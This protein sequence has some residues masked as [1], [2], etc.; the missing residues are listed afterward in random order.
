[1]RTAGLAIIAVLPGCTLSFDPSLLADARTVDCT[2]ADAAG[3]ITFGVPVLEALPS[4][5]SI[6]Y[7]PSLSRDL[8]TLYFASDRPGGAGGF[9]LYVATRA[10]AG[11]PFDDAVNLAALNSGMDDG[12]PSISASGLRLYFQSAREGARGLYV[13]ERAAETDTFTTSTRISIGLSSV[14]APDISAD[15]RALYFASDDPSGA[16][17]I[18]LWVMTRDEVGAP[19]NAPTDLSTVN[20]A[21]AESSPSIDTAGTTLYYQTDRDDPSSD[22][23]IATRTDLASAFA[24][25]GPELR[26]STA[27]IGEYDPDI[28]YDGQTL[29]LALNRAGGVGGTD[30]WLAT[31]QCPPAN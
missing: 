12:A 28:S 23:V 10:T 4:S 25:A 30:I 18:D 6:E 20:T 3:G 26:A 22:V 13:A 9:D 1:M 2:A 17:A 24:I 27:G 8:R 21:M 14:S 7:S 16:G 29:A 5:T 19:W 11:V 31:R 15:E